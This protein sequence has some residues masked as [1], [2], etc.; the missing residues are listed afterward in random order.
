MSVGCRLVFVCIRCYTATVKE[1]VVSKACKLPSFYSTMSR[2]LTCAVV[3]LELFFFFSFIINIKLM[4]LLFAPS[5]VYCHAHCV[6]LFPGLLRVI[7]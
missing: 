2:G 3:L 5:A 6:G 4:A 7:M 1:K